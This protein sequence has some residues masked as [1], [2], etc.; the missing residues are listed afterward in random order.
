MVGV[1]AASMLV[2]SAGGAQDAAIPAGLAAREIARFDAPT[3]NQGV[4][5]DEAHFYAIDN[6][7]IAKHDRTTGRLLQSWE[8]NPD[9]FKHMNSCML[10]EHEIVCAASNYPQVPMASS[11]EWFAADTLTHIRTRSLGPGRGSLTWL[12]WHDGSWWACFA[13]YDHRNG[14]PG[15]GT[16]Y[17]T[18]VRFSP[19]FV[20]LGAW[21]LPQP[22]LDRMAPYSSSGGLWGDDGLL[23]LTGHD[24]PEAYGV[25][26]PDAGT[27]LELEATVALPTPGQA[28]ARDAGNNHRIW[29]IDRAA[30]QV[31][32]S[33]FP[34]LAVQD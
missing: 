11:V 7:R 21:L 17:T 15:R 29:S 28:I 13:N 22:V 16:A 9:Q 10:A 14:E 1:A 24:L 20:E 19:E 2:A 8:G 23:W 27:R 32:L 30:R 3:A 6:S 31:V 18:I 33:E 5:A 4:V 25:R 12:D 34:P 26:V